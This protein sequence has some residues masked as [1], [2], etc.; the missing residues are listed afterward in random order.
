MKIKPLPQAK[1][2]VEGFKIVYAGEYTDKKGLVK[3]EYEYRSVG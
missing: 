3:E 1:F 2:K